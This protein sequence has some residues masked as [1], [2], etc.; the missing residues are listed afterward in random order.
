MTTSSP[1]Q[2][3]DSPVIFWF[4]A[5]KDV[6]QEMANTWLHH[7]ETDFIN[8]VEVL[9]SGSVTCTI[10]IQLDLTAI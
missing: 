2:I 5:N 8:Q 3:H 1:A 4:L 10:L 6:G 9:R 7:A